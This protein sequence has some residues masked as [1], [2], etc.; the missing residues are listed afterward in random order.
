MILLISLGANKSGAFNS[1]ANS[2]NTRSSDIDEMNNDITSFSD[3]NPSSASFDNVIIASSEN[4]EIF[5][6]IVL[7]KT[8]NQIVNDFNAMFLIPCYD[9][10]A[11]FGNVSAY[12]GTIVYATASCA[13]PNEDKRLTKKCEAYGN[14]V[15]V[16][17]TCP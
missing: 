14:W 10:G 4:S 8:R 3:G 6:D 7:F 17:K 2:Q 16:V 1:N 5:D 11:S 15:D 13:S 9:A 12:Y